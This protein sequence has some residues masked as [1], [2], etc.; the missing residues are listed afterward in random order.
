MIEKVF[1]LKKQHFSIFLIWLFVLSAL[2]G[3]YLGYLNWFIP[4]T[5]LNLLLGAVLL[6]WNVPI[7]SVKK[8]AIW[9][10][11]FVVGMA[12]E[13]VGV[14][15]GAI[16]GNYYY[17]EN[18]GLKL[19]G[20]PYLIGVNWA[21]LSFITAAISNHLSKQ[22]WWAVIIGATLMVGLDVLLEPMAVVF[23]FWHFENG[24]P[25]LKNFVA[26]FVVALLLQIMIHKTILIRDVHF[27]LHLFLSQVIF[28]GL[29]YL[30]IF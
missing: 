12:V 9:L 2:I 27:S 8:L 17:G 6:F 30:I 3:I 28:F 22:F 26:W 23:D 1:S 15:T 14:Q 19:M 13:I 24:F 10:V 4:K 16:F 5:P 11:A 18:L 21:V 7:N 20:V 29:C 25:P